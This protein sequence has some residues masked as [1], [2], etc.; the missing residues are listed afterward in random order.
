MPA[1]P[2]RMMKDTV[3]MISFPFV[4]L[5]VTD[6]ALRLVGE[7][8]FLIRN[9]PEFRLSYITKVG[10]YRLRLSMEGCCHSKG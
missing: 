9:I 6:V 10:E 5:A 1:M 4:P 3:S 7:C 8:M 2:M